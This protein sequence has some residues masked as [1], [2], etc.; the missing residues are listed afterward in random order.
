[1]IFTV[2][3]SSF[4]IVITRYFII[5]IFVFES[6]KYIIKFVRFNYP[7]TYKKKVNDSQV[8]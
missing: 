3:K 4:R 5:L 8:I 1:M 7:G 6:I 2:I